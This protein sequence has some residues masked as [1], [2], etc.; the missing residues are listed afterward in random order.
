MSTLR[1]VL[2]FPVL[3]SML[4][5][6]CSQSVSETDATSSISMQ[7]SSLT[8]VDD[9]FT[10]T[11]RNEVIDTIFYKGTIS[12]NGHDN[13]IDS[14]Y[15]AE[16]ASC[17]YGDI[18][19]ININNLQGIESLS[20][21]ENCYISTVK[22]VR[23]SNCPDMTDVSLISQM[24][25]LERLEITHAPVSDLS[26]AELDTKKQLR[27]IYII[28]TAID[29]IG[30]VS[31]IERL[32]SFLIADCPL[33]SEIDICN[34][35]ALT[36]LTIYRCGI[37]AISVNNCPNLVGVV[38]ADNNISEIDSLIDCGIEYQLQIEHNPVSYEDIISFAEKNPNC[39]LY[40][41]GD[42]FT[43]DELES[44]SA[45]DT[46]VAVGRQYDTVIAEDL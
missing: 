24:P 41:S 38:L 3:V 43:E 11:D 12:I 23:I 30:C 33:P 39:M 29:D 25:A 10:S 20:Y 17:L 22:E 15:L 19:A 26:S 46:I 6:G 32:Y 14:K 40:V 27:D 45:Y 44:L 7:D 42:H 31:G 28:D 4:M 16:F 18:E 5:V 1:N 8:T 9:S 21:F 35:P 36:S 34:L 37:E 2:L 13:A